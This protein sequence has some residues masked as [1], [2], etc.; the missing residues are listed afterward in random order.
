MIFIKKIIKNK[1]I[2]ALILRAELKVLNVCSASHGSG[3]NLKVD[4]ANYRPNKCQNLFDAEAV[5]EC[6]AD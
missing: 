2:L 6:E 3:V 4:L 1:K 5:A